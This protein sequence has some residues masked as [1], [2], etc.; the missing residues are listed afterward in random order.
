MGSTS[1]TLLVHYRAALRGLC[2]CPK[3]LGVCDPCEIPLRESQSLRAATVL[4]LEHFCSAP[5]RV[6]CLFRKATDPPISWGPDPRTHGLSEHRQSGSRELSQ[7]WA[8]A[9]AKLIEDKANGSAVIQMLC[10]KIPGLL[11]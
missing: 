1:N 4:G 5:E 6:K 9:I 11:P 10:H 7:R 2:S 8:G 3:R